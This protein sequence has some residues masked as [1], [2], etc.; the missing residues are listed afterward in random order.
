MGTSSIENKKRAFQ[1]ERHYSAFSFRSLVGC[2][3][4]IWLFYAK[5]SGKFSLLT[6]AGGINFYL[7]NSEKADGMIPKQDRHLVYS[8]GYRDPIQM[9]ANQGYEEATGEKASPKTVSK[10]WKE[11]PLTR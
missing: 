6:Q 4:G 1:K 2:S 11:K 7:G 5:Y 3:S 9:M 8:G 10:F